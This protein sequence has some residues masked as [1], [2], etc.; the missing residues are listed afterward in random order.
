MDNEHINI[1]IP[2]KGFLLPQHYMESLYPRLMQRILSETGEP[3]HLN[4]GPFLVPQHYFD[5]LEQKIYHRLN[6]MED[7]SK[8]GFTVPDQ[9]FEKFEDRLYQKMENASLETLLGV[10]KDSFKVPDHYF[11]TFDKKIKSTTVNNHST[12]KI[13]RFNFRQFAYAVAAMLIF[14]AGIFVFRLN[15]SS[16]KLNSDPLAS[17]T[18]EEMMAFAE[19]NIS[20]IDNQSIGE[21]L[22]EDELNQLP[23]IDVQDQENVDELID[24]LQ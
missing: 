11:E 22:T 4:K 16:N 20:S 19:D 23:G 13:L 5:Q 8:N 3:I 10:K 17:L 9:Y 2:E 15:Q 6:E 18:T 24:Y 7:N 12:S 1:K 14:V 21:L